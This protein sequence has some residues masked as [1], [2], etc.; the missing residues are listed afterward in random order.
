M[1]TATLVT[2]DDL[3]PVKE[4]L[5]AITERL[6]KLERR[7]PAADG[8]ALLTPKAVAHRYRVAEN[9]VYVACRDGSLR[10]EQRRGRGGRLCWLITADEAERWYRA[11]L[12]PETA[13][14]APV[15]E[16]PPPPAPPTKPRPLPPIAPAAPTRPTAGQRP[17]PGR[18]LPCDASRPVG[19]CFRAPST[20]D[21]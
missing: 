15:T 21:R 19:L 16:P 1:Q 17:P 8:L 9:A 12:R 3:A 11:G 5:A 18:A 7:N 13:D 14:T 2:A 10:A 4:A 6:A 20:A